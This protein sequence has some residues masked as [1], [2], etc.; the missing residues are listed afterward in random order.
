MSSPDRAYFEIVG[1]GQL[2]SGILANASWSA[3]AVVGSVN[4]YFTTFLVPGVS[5]TS[6][7]QATPSSSS[8]NLTDAVNC[9]I[10]TVYSTGKDGGTVFVYIGGN[11][12]TTAQFRISWYVSQF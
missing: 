11:P 12:A 10:V 2:P 3:G 7:V 5:P 6:V 9:P 8:A 4:T 1:N